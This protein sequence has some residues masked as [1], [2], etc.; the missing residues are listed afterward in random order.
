MRATQRV[1]IDTVDNIFNK[2]LLSPLSGNVYLRE[3]KSRYIEHLEID[4]GWMHRIPRASNVG[5]VVADYD[6]VSSDDVLSHPFS[7]Q[8]VLKNKRTSSNSLYVLYV[9][10][11]NLCILF[12]NGLWK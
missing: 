10:W 5:I 7:F 11:N 2:Y 6:M 9:I 4:L 8:P 3:E 1:D 12:T